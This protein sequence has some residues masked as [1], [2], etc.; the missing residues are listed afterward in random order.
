MLLKYIFY[1]KYR[2]DFKTPWKSFTKKERTGT[3]PDLELG[4][5][6]FK[7]QVGSGSKTKASCYRSTHCAQI[8]TPNA[9]PDPSGVTVYGTGTRSN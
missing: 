7:N 9:S 3:E 2:Y 6:L 8:K 4:L 5:E 1:Y